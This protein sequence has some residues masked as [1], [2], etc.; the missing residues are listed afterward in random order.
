MVF[1]PV[2]LR[3]TMPRLH[4]AC[5]CHSATR[6]TF[7]KLHVNHIRK[8]SAAGNWTRVFRVTGGNTNHYTTTDLVNSI[9]ILALGLSPM[10]TPIIINACKHQSLSSR[11]SKPR[12]N[13]QDTMSSQGDKQHAIAYFT[14]SNDRHVKHNRSNHR[15][16]EG[17]SGN[18]TR[19]LSHPKRE[20]YH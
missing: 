12:R 19:D 5:M 8:N 3:R 10:H 11:W 20:S 14:T 13:Q 9:N 7:L 17:C 18:W 16:E 4:N 15:S 2:Q 6:I 1:M